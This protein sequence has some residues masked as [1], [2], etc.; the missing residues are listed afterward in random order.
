MSGNVHRNPAPIFPCSVCLCNVTCR[1]RRPGKCFTCY[2]WVHFKLRLS[3]FF[4]VFLHFQLSLL[5]LSY[6]LDLGF[7]CGSSVHQHSV[8]FSGALHSIIPP[9]FTA[10]HSTFYQCFSSPSPL[11]A[12][13]HP[14][15]RFITNPT[16]F[17]FYSPS[18]LPALYLL[19]RLGFSNERRE[20]RASSVEFNL[21]SLFPVDLI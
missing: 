9:L 3:F 2:K 7:F 18:M 13:L 6:L 14:F 15:F 21:L 1:G 11:L 12:S 5:E 17:I 20:F 19:S 4:E 10:T 16:S 8:I